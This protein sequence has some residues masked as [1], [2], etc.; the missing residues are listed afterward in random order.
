MFCHQ[1]KPREAPPTPLTRVLLRVRVRLRVRAQIGP[2]RERAVALRAVERS[3]AGV[4][5]EVAVKQ[6]G[7]REGLAAHGAAAGQCVGA[8]VHLESAEG[9]VH[10][11]A[12][13]T[14]ERRRW[15]AVDQLGV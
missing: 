12:V 3:L 5:A 8:D 9:G 6:P 7:P 14:G 11:G 2:I 1:R 13:L 10:L 15:L 4:N